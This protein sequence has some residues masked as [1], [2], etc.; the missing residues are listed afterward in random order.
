MDK[1]QVDTRVWP[2]SS[3]SRTMISRMCLVSWPPA[4]IPSTPSKGNQVVSQR[5]LPVFLWVHKFTDSAK[6][7]VPLLSANHNST[8]T[9]FT[10]L[11]P[12]LHLA[13]SLVPQAD[14]EC[15][16][17]QAVSG[18]ICTDSAVNCGIF[19]ANFKQVRPGRGAL[20]Q[21]EA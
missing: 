3:A 5:D 7:T 4:T 18:N 20:F 14:G 8:G 11:R 19:G 9:N 15:T 12:N 10:I 21:N 16:T 17:I 6:F 2:C 13:R 1:L